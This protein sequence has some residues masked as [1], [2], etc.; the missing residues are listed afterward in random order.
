MSN[1][2]IKILNINN[3]E[4][5]KK[6]LRSFKNQYHIECIE[7]KDLTVEKLESIK[8]DIVI[9]SLI[10]RDLFIWK[11]KYSARLIQVFDTLEDVSL[12]AQVDDFI[13]LNQAD[14]KLRLAQV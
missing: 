1:I 14:T 13:V 7:E 9:S 5:L 11:K 10:C 6:L 8:P 3:N 4:L 12:D 2:R